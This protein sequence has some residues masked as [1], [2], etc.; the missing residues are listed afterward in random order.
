MEATVAE[1]IYVWIKPR[2][3]RVHETVVRLTTAWALS[4]GTGDTR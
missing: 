1:M 3:N 2:W 4:S